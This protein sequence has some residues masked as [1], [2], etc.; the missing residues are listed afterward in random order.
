MSGDPGYITF[1]WI[2]VVEEGSLRWSQ[3][4]MQVGSRVAHFAI[5]MGSNVQ[6]SYPVL[7]RL[8]V[9]LVSGMA[10]REGRFSRAGNQE[11]VLRA[12]VVVCGEV[13]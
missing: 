6:S 13:R 8:V 10:L 7:M 3:G 4:L 12:N 11:S 5:G 1:S 2:T 9:C